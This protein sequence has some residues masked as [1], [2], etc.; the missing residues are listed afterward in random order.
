MSL[1]A[2]QLK[3]KNALVTGSRRGLG[4]AIAVTLAKAGA[5]VGCHGRGGVEHGASA[6]EDSLVVDVFTPCREAY[7][8]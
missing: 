8:T 1:E 2:F 5:N 7:I 3:G 6:I 4:A